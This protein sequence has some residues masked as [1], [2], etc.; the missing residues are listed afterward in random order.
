[1]SFVAESE[2][3]LRVKATV[4]EDDDADDGDDDDDDV[5]VMNAADVAANNDQALAD[6]R[7]TEPSDLVDNDADAVCKPP[8]FYLLIESSTLIFFFFTKILSLLQMQLLIQLLW[9][10]HLLVS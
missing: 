9:I 3:C 5:V 6:S 8:F 2:I 4:N 1:L 7:Y 10:L